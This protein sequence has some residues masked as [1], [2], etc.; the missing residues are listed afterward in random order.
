MALINRLAVGLMPVV[1]KPIV[2]R[3]ASRYIAGERM[4]EAFAVVEKLQAEG[5]MATIDLLGEESD[6]L[7][8]AEQARDVYLK[9]LRGI[10]ERKLDANVSLKPTH[11]GL[12]LGYEKCRDL[13]ADVVRE[14]QKYGNF[15]RLDME[16]HTCTDETLRLFRDMRARYEGVGVVIQAYLRRSIND[17][18]QLAAG[19][20]N[21][22][23]CKGIYNEPRAIAFKNRAVIIR[24][25]ALLLEKLLRAGCY[26]GIATHC[27]ETVWHAERLIRELNLAPRQ[28][29]FQMLLG[30][31]P[32]LRR[33]LI[34][35]G[36]RL[37]VYVPF[38]EEWYPYSTRRLK[39]HPAMA[40]YVLRDFFGM[41][42]RNES[43]K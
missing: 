15:L 28:Y 30:V 12:R 3:V 33:L 32:E 19:Q 29:E 8:Q 25:F 39:E 14:T 34:A 23:L 6:R 43:G 13:V 40:G 26:V 1:P 31:E 41:N 5:A 18:N 11:F 24:N 10:A 2:G 4:A 37:R 20:A 21:I 35:A 7:S 17:V 22:R 9:L 16:D 38:G 27:E 36:H 42:K